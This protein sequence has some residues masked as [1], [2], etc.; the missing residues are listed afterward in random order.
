M[1]YTAGTLDCETENSYWLTVYA[2]D[3]GAV[4]MSASIE[5]FIEVIDFLLNS[6]SCKH[7]IK[8]TVCDI[9]IKKNFLFTMNHTNDLSKENSK[10]CFQI[11]RIK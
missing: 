3:R 10:I 4:P 2:T 7:K 8:N 9:A 6:I 1:I 5:V 11:N